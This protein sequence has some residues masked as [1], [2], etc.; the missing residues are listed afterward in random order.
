M[1]M[2]LVVVT[3]TPISTLPTPSQLEE[4]VA[5]INQFLNAARTGGGSRIETSRRHGS[6]TSH[7]FPVSWTRKRESRNYAST[8]VRNRRTLNGVQAPRESGS[9]NTL[10]RASAS[11]VNGPRTKET[12]RRRTNSAHVDQNKDDGSHSGKCT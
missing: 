1:T 8:S 9:R 3:Q 2:T 6:D 11:G 12:P 4:A 5:T 7:F 10:H